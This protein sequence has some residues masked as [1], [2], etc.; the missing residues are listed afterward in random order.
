VMSQGMPSVSM[1]AQRWGMA[2]DHIRNGNDGEMTIWLS[3]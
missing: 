2:K 3:G 1:S